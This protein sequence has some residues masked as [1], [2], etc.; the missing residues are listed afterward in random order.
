MWRN[1]SIWLKATRSYSLSTSIIPVAFGALWARWQNGG[2]YPGFAGLAITGGALLHLAANLL[3]DIFDCRAGIDH[4]G[5][6]QGGECL[7]QGI[8]SE[9][10]YRRAAIL[11][12]VVAT[13][14]GLYLFFK[15]Q[16]PLIIGLGAFG[17]LAAAGYAAGRY[18]PKYH[19]GGEALVFA[20]MGLGM[21]AGGYIT[22]MNAWSWPALVAGIPPA[23]GMVMI[24]LTNNI[25]DMATDQKSGVRTL[26][27]LMGYRPALRLLGTLFFLQFTLLFIWVIC[28]LLPTTALGGFA[29]LPVYLR[30]FNDILKN[31][32]GERHLRMAALL[33]ALFGAC[34]LLALL[35][36]L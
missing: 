13:G 10:A 4:P 36:P 19:A 2:F 23:I 12:I 5:G 6:P 16:N 26:P 18:S 28:D 27:L 30:W 1:P 11:F 34:L 24:M 20:S 29:T 25:R 22:Q 7:V 3:N 35:F 15:Q 21:T 8:V 14:I 32:P 17:L 33:H 31:G 9:K